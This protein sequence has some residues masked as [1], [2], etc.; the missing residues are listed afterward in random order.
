MTPSQRFID[1]YDVVH[2]F[3]TLSSLPLLNL[4]QTVSPAL[5]NIVRGIKIQRY[6]QILK[7]FVPSDWIECLKVFDASQ[8]VITGSCAL[9]MFLGPSNVP[10]P[11]DL[12]LLV[13]LLNVHR[14]RKFLRKIGYN[15]T[16]R[17]IRRPLEN[18]YVN[19]F[20][21]F[22]SPTTSQRITVS[23]S[24]GSDVLRLL[25]SSPTTADMIFMNHHGLIA[26]YSRLT[27]DYVAFRSQ[28]DRPSLLHAQ[29]SSASQSTFNVYQTC[30]E[31]CLN[32]WNRTKTLDHTSFYSITSP[33]S[34]NI[35][36]HVLNN[37]IEWR[38]NARC[39]SPSICAVSNNPINCI[40]DPPRFTTESNIKNHERK[41]SIDVAHITGLLYSCKIGHSVVVRVPYKNQDSLDKNNAD[42]DVDFWVAQRPRQKNLFDRDDLQVIIE[43]WPSDHTS[44]S[45]YNLSVFSE[46]PDRTGPK[47]FSITS[48]L[49]ARNTGHDINGDILVVKTS[50]KDCTS[51][52]DV[53][54]HQQQTIDSIIG[55]W[56]TER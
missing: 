24:T 46:H 29:V 36:S 15:R 27:T 25:L 9:A 20:E 44:E 41:I 52:L 40:W 45:K 10:S 12:N 54:D 3:L 4:M 34:K 38:L 39:L 23:E 31:F 16:T 11:R 13:P 47:S 37:C 17:D 43:T 51:F 48:V 53:Q 2:Y 5:L 28:P 49:P 30:N 7:T 14:L 21:I 6:E 55:A 32:H 22:C 26:F 8:T 33:P 50:V 1:N 42:L 56:A 35:Q 18:T 19:C